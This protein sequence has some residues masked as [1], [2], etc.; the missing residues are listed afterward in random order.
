M[1]KF[2]GTLLV[3]LSSLH[4]YA[5]NIPTLSTQQEIWKIKWAHTQPPD[6]PTRE[7][8]FIKSNEQQDSYRVFFNN[9]VEGYFNLKL[10]TKE[11]FSGVMTL[12]QSPQ[13]PEGDVC[14]LKGS[15]EQSKVNGT[16]HCDSQHEGTLT[17]EITTLLQIQNH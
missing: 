10:R 6:H 14:L 5:T 16:W 12:T 15:L 2:W 9:G 1:Y 7:I 17:G 3:S 8:L 11:A 13:L 4:V